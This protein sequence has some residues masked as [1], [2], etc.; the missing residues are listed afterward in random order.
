ATNKDLKKE[1]AENRFREDLYH[2]LGVIL[3]QVPALKDRKGDIPLLVD[4]FL[5]DIATEYGNKKK[6]ISERGIAEL[7]QYDW[8]GNIRE[9]RNVTERL[10][11]MA[12]DV[13]SE[14]DVKKYLI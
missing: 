7:Q 9:L 4:K 10:V 13:I 2:R 12:G 8:S 11:I 5:E 14:D 1:I 3:I 6:T